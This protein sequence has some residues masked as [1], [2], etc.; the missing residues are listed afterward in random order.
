M[1]GTERRLSMDL[2]EFAGGDVEDEAAD[3]EVVADPTVGLEFL[4]LLSDIGFDVLEGVKAHGRAGRE[5]GF[6]FDLRVHF[7]F[8]SLHH[9]AIGVVDHHHFIGSQHVVR[10]E[11]R[12]QGVVGDDAAGVA[13]HVRVL[14]NQA[15]CGQ[16]DARVHTGE[17]REMLAGARRDAVGFVGECSAGVCGEDVVDGGHRK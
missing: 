9:A 5:S 7:F 1:W 3:G 6:A 14:L 17:D 16:G 12:A 10:D 11:K 13:D 4:Y 2:A 8:G 15:Q